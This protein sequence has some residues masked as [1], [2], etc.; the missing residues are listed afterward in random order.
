MKIPSR[1]QNFIY[2]NSEKNGIAQLCAIK[3]KGKKKMHFSRI[4]STAIA[5]ALFLMLAMTIS[6]VALPMA[7]A[8]DP[9]W[10]IPTFAYINAEPNPVG[11]GQ[12]VLVVLWLDKTFPD[13]AI[14][15]TYRF[16][17]FELTI[18]KPD[19]K[20]ETVN[21]DYIVDT[22]S[23][24]Y[25]PYYPTEAGTYT[26]TFTFPGQDVT[27]YDYAP[28]SA[29][30]N[31]TFLPSSAQTHITVQE[32]PIPNP[33]VYPLPTEYWTRPIEGQNT[34][35]ATV[36]SNYLNPFGAA[37]QFAAERY[38][39]DAIAPNSPHV[40]WTKPI[41]FGGIVGGSNTG[42][43]DAAFYTG[44]SY[45]SRF[46]T[47]I[48]IYGRLYYDTPLS[49]DNNDGPY[50]CV[51]LR[52]GETLWENPD[53]SPTFGQLE[54]FDAPNQ[55]GVIPN[56]YLWQT[57]GRTWRA[58]D[59]LT[60]Q[61]VFN[62]TDVPSGTRVYGPNG[63]IL[64]YVLDA[65][66][67]WLAV[68]NITA[69]VANWP[70]S[71]Y[72][73]G[74]YRWRPL[75]QTIDG[76]L[77]VSYSWNVSIPALP[78]G[79]TLRYVIYDDLV[80]GSA[81]TQGGY[82][83]F[84]GGSSRFTYVDYAS[85]WALSLKEDN[86]G[87][88]LWSKNIDALPGNITLQLGSVGSVDPVNRVFFFSTRETM[89]WYGYSLDT[90]D[91]LWG[92]VGNARAF[93]YYPT[94]GSGGVA[95]VGWTAYGNLYTSGYGGEVFAIDSKTGNMAWS[96][97][98]DGEGNS[99][100]SGL[101]TP[102]GLYPIFI[103]AITDGKIYVYS[104]EHSPN[105]PLY[106]GEL[107]RCLNATTGEEIWTMDSWATIGGFS[108]QGFP[109]ADGYLA[110]LNAYDMQV[111]AIGK[112]PSATTVSAPDS[113]QSLGATVLVKGTVID[114]AAG[115]KQAEQAARFPNGVPAVSDKSMGDWME[116]VYMQKPRPADVTGVEVVVSVLDPNNNV[117]EVGRTNSDANGMFSV[118][119]TP[120]VPGKYAVIASFEGSE[121][122][123]QSHAE[124]ALFV[125]EA[126]AA[127]PVPTPTP[128]P[129]TDTYV[130]GTGIAII[131]AIAIVGVLLLRK[132]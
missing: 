18:T 82:P 12:R 66:N 60:G 41:Q 84:G 6:L 67:Q 25:Y 86:R 58:Y 39:P 83:S 27:D 100:N 117:Y 103:G 114:T 19:N 57:S 36:A 1:E 122:Y 72:Q 131:I 10:E 87:Q 113:A 106:K 17:N 85:F 69:V 97:G 29:Y 24:A 77:S 2:T 129:M 90:G 42:V 52:T 92:P 56:G 95:Q 9:A 55:H 35:W 63:E 70:T 22:T 37:Y 109:I 54:W 68:W 79:S 74:P 118:A 110:Y 102:W 115:T 3:L 61:S 71:I 16:H 43:E 49:N 33:P 119:F 47:P 101:N 98:G 31:D 65:A 48:I 128:A 127:T 105:I 126:P 8:H 78:S 80:M 111:Y 76:S 11:V 32:E 89:Q 104:S 130:I 23:S 116:Y 108:D 91:K 53:I 5:I 21:F 124:T 14:T 125:E 51:D 123:W 38:L 4:K 132:R 73:G 93:N 13:T 45:E 107:L 99:T 40:M 34:Q 50:I 112:G 88:L 28:N 26:F 81:H 20:T 121:S 94:V 59:A 62:I 7:N 120:E 44:L 46:S 64:I 96:Y 15:N 30:I 75:G